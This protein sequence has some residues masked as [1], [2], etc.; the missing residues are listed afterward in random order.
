M[1]AIRLTTA[2][3][4]AFV[5]AGVALL[6]SWRAPVVLAGGR[7][8]GSRR[9]GPGFV[10]RSHRGRHGARSGHRHRDDVAYQPLLIGASQ[11]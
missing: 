7:T 6:G 10:T 5:V 11:R 9:Y 3:I 8:T 1:P 2:V 4:G